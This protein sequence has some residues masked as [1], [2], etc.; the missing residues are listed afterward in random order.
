M[1][2]LISESRPATTRSVGPT[3]ERDGQ[4]ALMWDAL[5]VF[6]ALPLPPDAPEPEPEPTAL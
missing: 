2:K 3:T 1:P 5:E 4:A 6:A